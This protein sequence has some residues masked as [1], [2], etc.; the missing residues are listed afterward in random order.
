MGALK[1]I[2]EKIKR[3]KKR[4]DTYQMAITFAQAGLQ[5]EAKSLLKK[6]PDK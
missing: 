6:D 3:F 1:R 2:L 4:F 5:D